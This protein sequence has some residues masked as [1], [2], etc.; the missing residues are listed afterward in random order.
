MANHS[1]VAELIGNTV[2]SEVTAHAHLEG[3]VAPDSPLAEYVETLQ[4]LWVSEG[5][6]TDGTL[7]LVGQ[8]LQSFISCTFRLSYGSTNNWLQE[9]DTLRQVLLYKD[10]YS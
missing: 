2:G 1:L 5:I 10:Q 9:Q 7:Q 4:Y 3:P 6:K 8:L